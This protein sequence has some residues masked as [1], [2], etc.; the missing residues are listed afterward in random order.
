MNK[1]NTKK[2]LVGFLPM[3][4]NFGE[5]YPLIEIAKYC[6]KLGMN[7]IFF[8]S[9][10]PKYTYLVEKL[11]CDIVKIRD[12]PPEKYIHDIKNLEESISSGNISYEKACSGLI[13][14]KWE[15]IITN[16]INKELE[17]FK[18]TKIDILLS[19]GFEFTAHISTYLLNIPLVTLI[20]GAISQEYFKSKLAEFPDNYENFL[21]RFIPKYIKN[22]ITNWYI[23]LDKSN[24]KSYNKI[25]KKFSAPHKKSFLDLFYGD[26]T[27]VVDDWKFIGITEK[28]DIDLKRWIGPI[29]PPKLN[30]KTNG[31]LDKD[32]SEHIKK[33]GKS[34]L[35]TMGSSTTKNLFIKILKTLENTNYNVIAIY[36]NILSEEETSK[37]LLDDNLLLKKFVPS[38]GKINEKVDLAIIHGGR[39]TVYTAAYSGKPIV[40]IPMHFEQQC[41]LNNLSR[42]GT[43]FILSK[44]YFTREKL[45]SALNKIFN[46]YNAY[47]KNSKILKKM[48]P[49]PN[50]DEKAAKAILDIH[51]IENKD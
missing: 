43:G 31:K 27:L 46:N 47:L 40:G 49:E 30:D 2:P 13:D 10:A 44:K 7:I 11:G 1:S 4:N 34:I 45:V 25:S 36:T 21:T 14:K 17:L 9:Y 33:P 23:P 48:L 5:T 24:V 41:N 8:E 15:Q 3:L 22:K 35:L 19:S 37:L 50:G 32:I 28:K 29:L 38:I 26:Y 39:G 6:K 16:D 51:N 20:S 18:K 42:H 12:P